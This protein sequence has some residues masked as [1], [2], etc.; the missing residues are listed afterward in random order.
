MVAPAANPD[1]QRLQN[2]SRWLAAMCSLLIVALPV[3]VFAYWALADVAEVT[4]RAGL[5]S[6]AVTAPPQAWQRI[7]GALITQVP[8]A[9][10]L[11]GLWQARQCFKLFSAGQ[12]FT[13]RAVRFLRRF[14]GWVAASVAAGIVAQSAISVV[15]TLHNPPGLRHLA[16]SLGS[17]Q[18]FMLFFAGLVWLMAAVIGHGQTLAEENASFV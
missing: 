6:L 7:A 18:L 11:L 1:V 5:S 4:L 15:L 12:I 9:L 16:I 2:L 3:A 10:L 13:A 8:L 14:A 17:D